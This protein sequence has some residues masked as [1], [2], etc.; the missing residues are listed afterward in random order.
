MNQVLLY[1]FESLA[2]LTLMPPVDSPGGEFAHVV[3]VLP[4]AFFC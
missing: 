2:C 4:P 1:Y 3:V